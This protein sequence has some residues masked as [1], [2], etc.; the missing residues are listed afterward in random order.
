MHNYSQFFAVL[1]IFSKLLSHLFY[2]LIKTYFLGNSDFDF[3]ENSIPPPM[4]LSAPELGTDSPIFNLLKTSASSSELLHERAM[5][6][7]YEAAKAEEI[8]LE[9]RRKSIELRGLNIEIPKI[10]INSKDQQEKLELE[11]IHSF[12]RRLSGGAGQQ[13]RLRKYSLK[14]IDD[15]RGDD[16]RKLQKSNLTQLEKKELMMNRQRSESEEREEKIFEELRSKK[17]LKKQSS[18]ERR[19]INIADEGKWAD[20]YVSST[21]ESSYEDDEEDN[22]ERNRK[23]SFYNSEDEDEDTYHPRGLKMMPYSDKEPFEILTKRKEPPDPD[24]I[25]KPILKKKEHGEVSPLAM[26]PPTSPKLKRSLSPIPPSIFKKEISLAEASLNLPLLK[27]TIPEG[28][29]ISVPSRPRS[30]SLTY[31]DNSFLKEQPKPMKQRQRASSLLPQAELFQKSLVEDKPMSGRK[32]SFSLIPVEEKSEVTPENLYSSEKPTMSFLMQTISAAAT[33]SG[34]TAASIVLP[35]RLFEKQ[36]DA[37]EAKVVIDH[38]GDIVKTHGNKNKNPYLHKSRESLQRQ[39][40]ESLPRVDESNEELSYASNHLED[41]Q[42][43]KA[44]FKYDPLRSLPPSNYQNPV[45]SRVSGNNQIVKT[46]NISKYHDQYSTYKVHESIESRNVQSPPR[47]TASGSNSNT[48]TL[49]HE[50]ESRFKRS[51]SPSP[52]TRES[53]ESPLNIQSTSNEPRTFTHMSNAS[54][55]ENP[56][57]MNAS[58]P[59][60]EAN[61]ANT[62]Q[63]TRAF[64]PSFDSERSR[65]FSQSSDTSKKSDTST[66]SRTFSQKLEN[67]K[68]SSTNQRTRTFSPSSDSERREK[69]QPVIVPQGRKVSASPMR[70]S[71]KRKTA[72]PYPENRNISTSPLRLEDHYQNKIPSKRKTSPSP[73]RKRTEPSPMRTRPPMLKE[74]MTQTSEG[75]GS[76]DDSYPGSSS[77][78]SKQEELIAKAEVKVHRF[79][80]YL[81]DLVMF[82]V[83]CWLYLFKD[84]LLAV[85][86][87]LVLVYRQLQAEISKRIPNWL[88]R[89]VR[90]LRRIKGGNNS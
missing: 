22:I 84:E 1:F 11:R 18:T 42:N 13:L 31:E 74:I 16:L 59:E 90:R 66:K 79:F 36:K 71:E 17:E 87:L 65:T 48:S 27:R 41:K 80:D 19:K 88:V 58:S 43:N 51:M 37:E 85:P 57:R 47:I 75:L 46:D 60:L 62:N 70:K 82:M 72:S 3:G 35:D 33:I 6:R 7:L 2:I 4:S 45:S 28:E 12:K 23:F 14:D 54:S 78:S 40:I 9:R 76:F 20:D 5:I 83:A 26:S 30:S 67:G 55:N 63:R 10:Q 89:F 56:S 49:G 69:S 52:E 64:S 21:E 25:P 38:Y 32:R 50:I 39:S 24:F 86:V 15:L 34:I 29:E 73:M 44:G 53:K 8:E 77:R 68:K 61:K 81:T